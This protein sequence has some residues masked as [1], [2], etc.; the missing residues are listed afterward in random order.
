MEHSVHC[1][2]PNWMLS[3]CTTRIVDSNY[4]MWQLFTKPLSTVRSL[5]VLLFPYFNVFCLLCETALCFFSY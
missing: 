3:Q 2:L 1:A 4:I 5:V